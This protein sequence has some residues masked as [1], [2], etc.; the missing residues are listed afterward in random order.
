MEN[1]DPD[2]VAMMGQNGGR[3]VVVGDGR[4]GGGNYSTVTTTRSVGGANT[5][6]GRG[7]EIIR[8]GGGQQGGYTTSRS[9]GGSGVQVV[10]P[11]VGSYTTTTT[12]RTMGGGGGEIMVNGGQIDP[13]R[14]VT[15]ASN[16]SAYQ[17]E[18]Y[19]TTYT[20]G[21]PGD[22]QVVRVIE[23]TTTTGGGGESG[24]YGIERA[25]TEQDSYAEA[26]YP[27]SREDTGVSLGQIIQ[28]RAVDDGVKKGTAGS[29]TITETTT[30]TKQPWETKVDD[31]QAMNAA[32]TRR[33]EK[34]VMTRELWSN[35]APYA[36]SQQTQYRIIEESQ[37]STTKVVYEEPIVNTYKTM[38][39]TTP[40][41]H[42]RSPRTYKTITT[43]EDLDSPRVVVRQ[44]SPRPQPK[45][46]EEYVTYE[47]PPPER[48]V[49]VR[50][51]SPRRVV[52]YVEYEETP[53]P[54]PQP[55]R[56]VVEEIIEY[57]PPPR[58]PSPDSS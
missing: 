6:N 53:P 10:G 13:N 27:K 42:P 54:P 2:M 9:I 48:V 40:K 45:I 32:H 4:V 56:R 39:S 26:G 37:P 23:E 49:T 19:T 11:N 3:Q 57:Q 44:A 29:Y 16:S 1:G 12:S 30:N 20:N 52:E 5:Y 28:H 46:V 38:S 21:D 15:F 24:Q 31:W 47:E 7:G 55:E 8:V 25:Y 33:I 34:P 22:Q 35:D 51:E 58:D 17:P 14:R 50:P 36:E 43:E 18:S 41:I